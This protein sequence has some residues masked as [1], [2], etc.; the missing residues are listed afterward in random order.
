VNPGQYAFFVVV[1]R[2]FKI[3]S[4]RNADLGHIPGRSR[5]LSTEEIAEIVD[6]IANWQR[7]PLT[8]IALPPN[9]EGLKRLSCGS[10]HCEWTAADAE[11]PAAV[12]AIV[13]WLAQHVMF[14]FSTLEKGSHAMAESQNDVKLT[15]AELAA[16]NFLIED[17]KESGSTA[18]LAPAA[19]TAV[20]RE[21]VKAVA[22]EAAFEAV[23]EV[24]RQ[25]VEKVFG[26]AVLK[27]DGLDTKARDASAQISEA[28]RREP[29][30]ESLIALRDSLAEQ[31]KGK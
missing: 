28:L 15:K 26:S 17:A 30:L 19:V 11:Y 1:S 3:S 2:E 6:L 18:S 7:D 23:R 31:S 9:D 16:L 29:T 4:Y 12:H 14:V 24:A 22:K 5:P 20:V 25:A 8:R 13:T 21:V 10:L 27:T